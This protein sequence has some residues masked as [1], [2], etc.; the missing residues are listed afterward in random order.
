MNFFSSCYFAITCVVL[1]A[2]PLIAQSNI[3]ADAQATALGNATIAD[4]AINAVFHNAAAL[5]RQTAP[6]IICSYEQRF[7][8]TA[9]K[10]IATAYVQPS[11]SGALGFSLSQYGSETYREQKIGIGYGKKL[12]TNLAVGVQLDVLW[13]QMRE[14]GSRLVPL[15][16]ASVWYR[17]NTDIDVGASIYNPLAMSVS[18]YDR[19]TTTLRLGAVYRVNTQTRWLAE[20]QQ[21]SEHA[22]RFKSGIAYQPNELLTARVGVQTS[23]TVFSL[24]VGL[25]LS[26]RWTI[27]VAVAQ[28]FIVGITPVVNVVYALT[29]AVATKTE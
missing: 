28:H 2:T 12:A 21:D 22:W 14:Y 17:V 13:L 5:T 24:G 20:L 6:S 7:A 25:A 4:A 9:F 27:E 15:V 11:A 26:K 19:Y 1:S 10:T 3:A 23:P 29:D 18:E 8:L 16:G